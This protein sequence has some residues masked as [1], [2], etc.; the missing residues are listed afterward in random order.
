VAFQLQRWLVQSRIEC[1]RR[2]SRF[3]EEL[4]QLRWIQSM[5]ADAAGSETKHVRFGAKI[6]GHRRKNAPGTV[7]V[8]RE[9]ATKL[10]RDPRARH[11]L[12]VTWIASLRFA[13][14]SKA[15]HKV[16]SFF[17][18]LWKRKPAPTRFTHSPPHLS[19]NTE[20][21][22]LSGKQAPR[23]SRVNRRPVLFNMSSTLRVNVHP[24]ICP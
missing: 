11:L 18:P 20:A 9:V 21:R 23:D 12:Y 24:V 10:N 15:S 19:N 22:R 16:T 5:T 3:L 6:S 2:I 17:R 8:G 1:S 14:P 13:R 7:A 4:D